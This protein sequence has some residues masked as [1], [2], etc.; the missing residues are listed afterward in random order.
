MHVNKVILNALPISLRERLISLR[1]NYFGGYQVVSY[2][3]EG[4]DRILQRIFDK[5]N[6]GF[7]VDVGAHH[8]MRFS[9]TY[10]FYKKGWKGINIDAMPGSMRGFE[11]I[12]PRDINIEQAIANVEKELTFYRFN[13]PALN[14]F[15][16]A[17]SLH[18][19][20][21]KNPYNIV[22][23][24]KLLTQKLSSVLDK[25]LLPNQA[26]DF[27]SVDVEGLDLD[28]L[29][30]NDWEKYSPEIIVVEI[31]A[32]HL[33]EL[34]ESDIHRYLSEL[35]YELC[36]RCVLSAIYKRVD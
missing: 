19:D 27:L 21:A 5:R 4:E 24:E 29:H 20:S 12:R 8:P 22:E 26:I 17:L 13:E 6:T 11:A 35:G 33:D 34:L 30:S 32:K 10:L 16:K 1:N 14:S 9:N 31:R 18:R 7:Y 36:S 23:E 3:Q 2:A 15:S 25:Y 28:V